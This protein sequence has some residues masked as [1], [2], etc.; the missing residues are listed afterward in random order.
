MNTEYVVSAFYFCF[1]RLD[2]LSNL[3]IV[4]EYDFK[5]AHLR[6]KKRMSFL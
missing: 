4:T 3:K 2:M 6:K 5:S 1:N